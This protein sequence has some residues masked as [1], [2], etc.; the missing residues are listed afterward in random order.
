MEINRT[1]A[2]IY[3]DD[4][5]YLDHLAP[6]CCLLNIPL[7]VTEHLLALLARQ[8][9]P[10]LS[11]IQ[12]DYLT[13][14]EECIQRFDQLFCCTPR[15]LFDEV[16]FFAETIYRKKIR[17]IWCPHG[18]SDKGDLTEHFN[19]LRQESAALIYGPQ[20]ANRFQKANLDTL[21]GNSVTTGNFR[22]QFY[23]AHKKFYDALVDEHLFQK[24]PP[25]SRNFL[26]AP[27]WD[28]AFF[29]KVSSIIDQLPPDANL[30][31]KFHPNLIK[32][33]AYEIETLFLD[34][35]NH[36]RLHLLS[37]FPPIYPILNRIDLYI[38]ETS[39]ISY[40][41]LTFDRPLLLLGKPI[42]ENRRKIYNEAFG[43]SPKPLSQLQLE[44]R[45]LIQ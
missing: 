9:Y 23:L 41:F 5:H 2:L 17:T 28:E 42:P 24:L 10:S 37:N 3:G 1:A 45:Y 40:D 13:L 18:N 16:F 34:Y 8:C 19:A 39:S 12:I 38:G 44:L 32:K 6:L 15:P 33:K 22:Y 26:Y 21:L 11:V 25:A 7:V 29:S 4:E 36:P 27:S 14:A 31:I 35:A 20:M 43:A 30:I